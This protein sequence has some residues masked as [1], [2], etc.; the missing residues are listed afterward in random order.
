MTAAARLA[1]NLLAG[2]GNRVEIDCG[3]GGVL[4][5]AGVRFPVDKSVMD[6]MRKYLGIRGVCSALCCHVDD[7]KYAL[8]VFYGDPEAT[9][10]DCRA[11]VNPVVERLKE[12]LR[13]GA[14]DP[15]RA[16]VA[17]RLPFE[18]CQ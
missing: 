15:L 17:V 9:N 14:A 4:R 12:A 8:F 7:G 5:T 11:I 1:E 13:A 6:D 10:Q 16:L 2:D 18:V 3:P